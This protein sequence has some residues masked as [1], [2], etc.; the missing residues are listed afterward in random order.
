LLF[1]RNR[2]VPSGTFQPIES[3]CAAL[4]ENTPTGKR[5]CIAQAILASDQG[6]CP[7]LAIDDPASILAGAGQAP[8][9]AGYWLVQRRCASVPQAKRDAN[10][11]L[12]NAM[13]HVE[14]P[15]PW[16]AVRLADT[17]GNPGGATPTS[18]GVESRNN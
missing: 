16:L 6:R 18:Q 8:W 5:I 2:P 1:Q 7:D 4:Q 15:P 9:L 10:E 13:T 17:S 11:Q 3:A 14:T 12:R